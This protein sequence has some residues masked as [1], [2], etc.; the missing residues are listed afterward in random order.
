MQD[1]YDLCRR[2]RTPL[3]HWMQCYL[4]GGGVMK[5]CLGIIANP[6]QDG[7]CIIKNNPFYNPEFCTC[8]E[9]EE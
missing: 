6:E 3:P 5:P 4:S 7:T 8:K 9:E 1:G 2:K